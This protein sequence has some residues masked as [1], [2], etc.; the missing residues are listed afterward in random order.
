MLTVMQYALQLYG[1]N[2][3][4]GTAKDDESDDEGGDIESEIQKEIEGIRKPTTDPLFRPAK[5]DTPCCK[6]SGECATVRV[7]C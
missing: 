6:L 7:G 2:Q 1:V 5:I 4:G 3:N